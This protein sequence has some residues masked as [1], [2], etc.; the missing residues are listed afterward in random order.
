MPCSFQYSAFTFEIISH[1]HIFH[2]IK[3]RS[4]IRINT[5]E[6]GLSH[7]SVQEKQFSSVLNATNT[8]LPHV[9]YLIIQ[10]SNY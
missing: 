8:N 10:I 1:Y 9:M 6:E 3:R 7:F 2:Y 5:G 4:D